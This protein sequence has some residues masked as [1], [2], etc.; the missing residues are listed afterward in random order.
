M[1]FSIWMGID[2]L[3]EIVVVEWMKNLSS[4]PSSYSVAQ[5]F[6]FV[7]KIPNKHDSASSNC[8]IKKISLK[9]H[10]EI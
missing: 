1:C 9:K 2:R 8:L 7:F 6:H 3:I 4:T 5:L 10:L